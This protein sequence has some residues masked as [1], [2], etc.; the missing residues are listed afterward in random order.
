MLFYREIVK[1]LRA[2]YFKYIFR[3]IQRTRKQSRWYVKDG[4]PKYVK[5]TNPILK[6]CPIENLAQKW[7]LDF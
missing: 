2:E 7:T 6:N 4:N 3:I 1:N 5:F